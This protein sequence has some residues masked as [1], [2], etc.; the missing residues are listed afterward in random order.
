A[1]APAGG[2]TISHAQA[3]RRFASRPGLPLHFERSA[4]GLRRFLANIGVGTDGF[5]IVDI[6]MVNPPLHA[7]DVQD[8]DRLGQASITDGQSIDDGSMLAE[9]DRKSTRLNS[10]HVSI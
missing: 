3:P 9:R 2:V 6:D 5:L 10:S 1:E 8:H 7:C 4:P